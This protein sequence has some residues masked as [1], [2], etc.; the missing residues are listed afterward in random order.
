MAV[1]A[2]G[3]LK[4]PAA[5][6]VSPVP[7]RLFSARLEPVVAS[8]GP[9]MADPPLERR[10]S[11]YG[12]HVQGV[13]FRYTVRQVA[14][15]YP[16]TGFVRNLPDGRVELVVEGAPGDLDR[17]MATIAERMSGY[18]RDLKVDVRPAIGEFEGFEIRH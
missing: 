10:Q 15:R 9:A 14:Q 11:Y 13:G 5:R 2:A 3:I 6:A 4:G 17:F 8:R 7:A 16:V 1:G 12:G 18:I